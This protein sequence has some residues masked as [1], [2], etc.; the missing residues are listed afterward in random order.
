MP[1]ILL[2]SHT[3][4]TNPANIWTKLLLLHCTCNTLRMK[5][6]ALTCLLPFVTLFHS[7]AQGQVPVLRSG[8]Q[9]ILAKPSN[10]STRS[11][12]SKHSGSS[13][14]YAT[15]PFGSSQTSTDG[16]F[17]EG[18]TVVNLGLGLG[19]GYGSH[20]RSV[21]A[22]PAMSISAER[23]VL[24]GIGPGV[25]G[26]GGL[27]GYK[28]YRYDYPGSEY[29]ASWRNIVVLIRGT[30][31]YDL[32]QVPNLDTYVGASIGARF[33]HYKDTYLET[34]PAS[35][36]DPGLGTKFETGVFLGGRY[37]LTNRIGAFAE[38]G[39]DMS[40]FKLGLTGRF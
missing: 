38:L 28:G 19:M 4:Y 16:L 20:F 36:Y 8:G 14:T 15:P 24:E 17:R 3:F 11:S 37:Y 12:T 6:L 27:I 31:H 35:E 9:N 25:I 7:S 18:T 2:S 40:Y 1:Q 10:A 5:I 13:T 34:V 21:D 22:T 39:Y 30:Y 33:E 26:L 32:L 29:N 23:G